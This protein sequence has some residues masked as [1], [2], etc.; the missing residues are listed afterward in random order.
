MPDNFF[1]GPGPNATCDGHHGYRLDL[2]RDEDR[3]DFALLTEGMCPG[4]GITAERTADGFARC[5][6]CEVEWAV[7]ADRLILRIAVPQPTA[8]SAAPTAVEQA[9][10]E[11]GR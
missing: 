1:T 3:R 10:N 9:D 6:C 11:T 7:D 8:A 2:A 5:P 4:C